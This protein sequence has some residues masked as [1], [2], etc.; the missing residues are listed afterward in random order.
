MSAGLW[1]RDADRWWGTRQAVACAFGRRVAVRALAFVP[2]A[3]PSGMAAALPTSNLNFTCGELATKSPSSA[4]HS[5]AI[6]LPR[7][8]E[9]PS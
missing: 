3:K 8:N 5:H 6:E 4:R 1:A 2:A 7:H 9:T